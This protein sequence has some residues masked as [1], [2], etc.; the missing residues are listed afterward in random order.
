MSTSH[1]FLLRTS[2]WRKSFNILS[3]QNTWKITPRWAIQHAILQLVRFRQLIW[4]TKTG[5][6]KCFYH[7]F[8]GNCLK[9]WRWIQFENDLILGWIWCWWTHK[10]F[11]FE[12]FHLF[13][14]IF[15]CTMYIFVASFQT[16]CLF[17]ASLHLCSCPSKQV[18]LKRQKIQYHDFLFFFQI[19]IHL[20]YSNLHNRG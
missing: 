13:F 20:G 10:L 8:E 4:F 5:F 3:S 14:R 9:G 17:W 11:Q 2:A 6:R 1:K 7:K 15:S 12:N 16:G 18:N 19:C